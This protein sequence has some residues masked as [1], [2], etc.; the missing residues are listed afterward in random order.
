[1]PKPRGQE[2][3]LFVECDVVVLGD[4]LQD[5][6]VLVQNWLIDLGRLLDVGVLCRLRA[7]DLIQAVL[8]PVDS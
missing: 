5:L 3:L 8:L 1:M 6:V 2:L 4:L 7:L